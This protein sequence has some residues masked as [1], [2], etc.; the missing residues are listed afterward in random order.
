MENYL[1]N[2]KKCE[3]KNKRKE[4]ERKEKNENYCFIDDNI[5]FEIE[6]LYRRTI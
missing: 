3:Q 6:V 4:R 5:D 2:D 1:G